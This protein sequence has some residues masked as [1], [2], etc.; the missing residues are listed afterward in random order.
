MT[1]R[2]EK[3]QVSSSRVEIEQEIE[4][5][6]REEKA[7]KEKLANVRDQ[8]ARKEAELVLFATISKSAL[9]SILSALA[10]CQL[11]GAC[12]PLGHSLICSANPSRKPCQKPDGGTCSFMGHDPSCPHFLTAASPNPRGRTSVEMTDQK[13]AMLSTITKTSVLDPHPPTSLVSTDKPAA[14]LT[15]PTVAVSVSISDINTK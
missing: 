12:H 1:N 4:R 14:P 11:S 7:A 3:T 13:T 9:P 2:D 10:P 6:K 15:L 8:L 5:L